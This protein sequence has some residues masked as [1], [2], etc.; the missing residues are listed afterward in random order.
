[1]KRFFDILFSIVALLLSAPIF[2]VVSLLIKAD[3]K[4]PVFFIQD[5]VGRGGELFQVIKFRTMVEYAAQF[6]PKLT[7][8]NDPRITAMGQ[9]LRWLKIDELPQL[10]NVLRGEMSIIGPRPEIPSI[11]ALYREEQRGVLSV[12]PGMLG[13]SQ[14]VGRDEL[15]KYPD[16]V[17]VESYYVEHI[18]PEKLA[19]DL[20]YVQN[21]SF[22]TDI[23]YLF[24]GLQETIAGSIKVKYILESRRRIFYLGLDV[25]FSCLSYVIAYHLRFD[26]V[27][28]PAEYTYLMRVLLIILLMRPLAFVY[29]GLYQRLWK[30]TDV[31][32]IAAVVK[33]V[34]L[35]TIV[36]IFFSYLVGLV[37]HPR[38]VFIVD[39]FLLVTFMS[40]FRMSFRF[41]LTNGKS[42]NGK[43]KNILIVGAGDTGESLVREVLKNGNL[44]YQ[45]VGF[46]D[47]D[48]QKKGA[49]IH[50]L[51]VLG[52]CYDIPQI[53]KL[54]GVNEVIVAISR[55]SAGEMTRILGFCDK[56]RVK[57]RIVPSVSDLISGKVHIAKIRN[58]EVSDLLG[59]EVLR[60]DLSAIR[61]LISGKAVLITGGAGSIGSEL[62]RQILPFGPDRVI[63]VDKAENAL[64]SLEWEIERNFPNVKVSYCLRDVI[65]KS[66][67]REIFVHHRPRVVFHCAGL[68]HIP[69]VEGH[70]EKAFHGNVYGTK[71]IADLAHTY[72]AERFVLLSSDKA[73]YPTSVVGATQKVAELYLEEKSRKSKVQY[74]TIRFG[75]VLNSR[76]TFLEFFKRQ[77]R[78]GG[79]LTITHPEAKGYFMTAVE[80][81]ELILQATAM[82]EDSQTLV[83]DLGEK[84]RIADIA[85]KLIRLSGLKPGK[86][87][88][89]EY[90]G[91]R[92]GEKLVE[93]L[94]EHGE[95]IIPT[96]HEKIK[97]IRFRH[98]RD[99]SLDSVIADMAKMAKRADRIGVMKKLR[100]LVPT[101]Q[102]P[103]DTAVQS[104]R[105][106]RGLSETRLTSSSMA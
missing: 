1:M 62:C 64:R 32:D 66:R 80:A 52:R 36:I 54:K 30:Y 19:T 51:K 12:R 8:K 65:E 26:W 47:D 70:E 74:L 42:R 73:A 35:S 72:R 22:V 21:A 94:W 13:P 24:R 61:R 86:D 90:V 71:V 87:V 4:G 97:Q 41:R 89:I 58:V 33:A 6:G 9:I 11:V 98:G 91:L 82:A 63:I 25:L 60:L 23:L 43:R 76:G 105:P 38:S 67:L 45:P 2:L 56:A 68:N 31:H 57:Y 40:G 5:R 28:P 16:D 59:R 55:A 99:Q 88:A 79:P 48:P 69:I 83:L 46:I 77:L 34:S 53:V 17:D 14:I 96:R 85:E 100:D 101:Y 15:E 49:F 10:L 7:A 78:E 75:T 81:V 20:E 27:I 18:L 3:S 84:A 102:Y 95:R 104:P 44:G 92:P 39:W 50:G 106:P 37:G 103:D 29:F 93:E